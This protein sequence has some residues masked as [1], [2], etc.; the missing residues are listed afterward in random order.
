MKRDPYNHKEKWEKWKKESQKRG[1]V[2]INKANSDI[3]LKY[4][5]DM[6]KGLNVSMMSERGPRSP[7]RLNTLKDRMVGFAKQF[8]QKFNLSKITSITEDQILS[9]FAD[10]DSGAIT[11]RYGNRYKSIDTY[12]KITRFDTWQWT[13]AGERE[14]KQALRKVLLKYK[15]HK[16]EDLFDKA[17]QYIREHY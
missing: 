4:L 14:I 9:F 3:I 10:M 2:G 13:N 7:I 5:I 12:V 1:I 6:E 11:T 15:L 16:E 8:E 17:Y